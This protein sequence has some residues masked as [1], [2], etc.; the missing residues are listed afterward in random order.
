MDRTT[1]KY[2][3][4]GSWKHWWTFFLTCYRPTTTTTNQLIKKIIHRSLVAALCKIFITVHVQHMDITFSDVLSALGL[5]PSFS[6]FCG[7][8][9]IGSASGLASLVS[10]SGSGSGCDS[11][12]DSGSGS[13]SA[14]STGSGLGGGEGEVCCGS[15]SSFAS[16]FFW[17]YIFHEI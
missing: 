7:C 12:C 5:W 11:G 3:I 9:V 13:G 17:N 4:L 15:A 6:D 2:V 16:R 10:G 14:V 1:S 8:W